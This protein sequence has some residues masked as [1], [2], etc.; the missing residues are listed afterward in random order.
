MKAELDLDLGN[1]LIDQRYHLVGVLERLAGGD[2]YCEINM[3]RVLST[4]KT[5]DEQLKEMGLQ[6]YRYYS[7]E[8]E[9]GAKKVGLLNVYGERVR[10]HK[11]KLGTEI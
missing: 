4:I 7:D 1:S 8:E 11:S 10:N 6:R 5:I 3:R 2:I 9:W